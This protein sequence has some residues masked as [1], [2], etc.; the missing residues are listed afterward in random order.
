MNTNTTIGLDLGNKNHKAVGLAPDGKQLFRE[1]VVNTPESVRDFFTRHAGATIGMETGTHVRWI[2]ALAR[3]C[4]C[5]PVV[6]NARKLRLIFESSRKND[7]RDAE[8]IAELCRTNK[9]LFHPVELRPEERHRLLQL[10]KMRDVL[11]ASRTKLVNSVRGLCK[12]NGVF[13]PKCSAESLPDRAD[14]IPAG[15]REMFEPV[16]EE[17]ESLTG[18]IRQLDGMIRRYAGDHFKEDIELLQT[19]PG[20][21]MVTSTCFVAAI[22]SAEIFDDPRDAGAYFGLVPRQDQ[23][24]DTDRPRH[25]TKE[26]NRM[27]RRNL[28][29]AANCILRDASPETGLKRFGLRVRGSG[30]GKVAKRRAKTAVARKLA[31]VMA[32]MLK[33]RKP[34]DGSAGKVNRA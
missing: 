27:A 18:R 34:Y 17:I 8:T 9:K 32:A 26:G 22:P 6:G 19:I 14:A 3:E 20:V 5:R 2:A 10:L 23:S 13:L 11:V 24:G 4:G 1:E 7:W 16:L 21:G 29:T 30:N 31:V 25:I 33:S 28:V 12:A 15:D